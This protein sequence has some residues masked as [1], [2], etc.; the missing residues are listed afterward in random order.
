VELIENEEDRKEN[1]IRNQEI[2]MEVEITLKKVKF[3]GLIRVLFNTDV[4]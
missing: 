1:E 2:G 3:L 4:V